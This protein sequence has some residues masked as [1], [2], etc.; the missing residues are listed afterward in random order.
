MF[1]HGDANRSSTRVYALRS[2]DRSVYGSSGFCLF[3]SRVSSAHLGVC[4]ASVCSL[5]KRKAERL[6]GPSGRYE[7]RD[8]HETLDWGAQALEGTK[9]GR[10]SASAYRL[11]SF[12]VGGLL[13]GK[14]RSQ[15][16][17]VPLPSRSDQVTPRMIEFLV[18]TSVISG[19][20]EDGCSRTALVYYWCKRK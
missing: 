1:D 17:E 2:A 6:L 19:I 15:M 14:C 10:E 13:S 4:P 3:Q 5:T 20:A 16:H 9:R 12:A 11:V 18:V 7:G 8:L